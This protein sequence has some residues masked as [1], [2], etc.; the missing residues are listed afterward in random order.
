M[1]NLVIGRAKKRLRDAVAKRIGV[2]F[3]TTPPIQ[4]KSSPR[5]GE[6][7]SAREHDGVLSQALTV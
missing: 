7:T 3:L 4:Q 6:V 1:A 2:N 5:P